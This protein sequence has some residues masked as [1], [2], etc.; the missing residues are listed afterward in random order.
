MAEIGSISSSSPA[1]AFQRPNNAGSQGQDGGSTNAVEDRVQLSSDARA[2]SVQ[3]TAQDAAAS[4]SSPTVDQRIEA[5]A[6][7]ARESI[8]NQDISTD[9][10]DIQEANT[11]N[12]A[13]PPEQDINTL[14]R[15]RAEQSSSDGA[16]SSA[17][18]SV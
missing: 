7:P 17:E 2:Q 14:S 5:N 12:S 16:L 8:Q 9:V 6:D 1:Q 15:E 10:S 11:E 18:S 13:A 3:A 4:G